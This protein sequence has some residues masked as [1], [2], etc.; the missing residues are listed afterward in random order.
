MIEQPQAT[1]TFRTGAPTDLSGATQF[2]RDPASTRRAL[3]DLKFA[4][5]PA[6]GLTGEVLMEIGDDAA[7]CAVRP[8]GD[9]AMTQPDHVA[10]AETT[11]KGPSVG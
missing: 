4:L 7:F 1:F 6:Y 3:A 8:F 10:E 2:H 11:V 9:P 5:P